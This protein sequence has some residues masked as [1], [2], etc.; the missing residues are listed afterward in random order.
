[1]PRR[2]HPVTPVLDLVV[3]VRQLA[4]P[5]VILALGGAQGAIGVGTILVLVGVVL[6]LRVLR[7]TRYSYRIDGDALRIEEGVLR[8]TRRTVPLAR[9]Q[10]VDVQRALR[11]RVASV[12]ALRVDTAGGSGGAEAT[13]DVISLDE[14][15]RLRRVLLAARDRAQARTDPQVHSSGGPV[16]PAPGTPAAA[17]GAGPP[18]SAPQPEGSGTTHAGE[19]TAAGRGRRPRTT[20]RWSSRS[21]PG[22]WPSGA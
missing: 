12:A 21:R 14:A 13:L 7:W 4:L 5:I 18:G 3:Q 11:H 19:P 6:G 8:R 17:P 15:E 2:L 16:G 20:A 9:I 10:Q 1:V 22:G